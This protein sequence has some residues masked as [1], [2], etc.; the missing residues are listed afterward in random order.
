MHVHLVDGTPTWHKGELGCAGLSST[1]VVSTSQSFASCAWPPI[2][3]GHQ[4]E[5]TSR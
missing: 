4:S 1:V 5:V 2:D 3:L